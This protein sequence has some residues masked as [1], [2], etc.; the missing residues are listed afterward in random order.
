MRQAGDCAEIARTGCLSAYE[1]AQGHL[2][3]R[4][5][6]GQT[7][8]FASPNNNGCHQAETAAHSPEDE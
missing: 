1:F 2:P 3:D 8:L 5:R 6:T 4:R 7:G